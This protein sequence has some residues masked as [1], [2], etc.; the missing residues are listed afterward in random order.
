MRH[1]SFLKGGDIRK[2][3][4]AD[5]CLLSLLTDNRP[6]EKAKSSGPS[7]Q[8][9]QGHLFL[10]P[11]CE[12][13]LLSLKRL[14]SQCEAFWSQKI[15]FYLKKKK[16][17]EW[18]KGKKS[19]KISLLS[20]PLYPLLWTSFPP[21]LIGA[22]SVKPLHNSVSGEILALIRVLWGCKKIFFLLTQ[23][24]GCPKT[25]EKMKSNIFFMFIQTSSFKHHDKE[26]IGFIT[27]QY[28]FV[29]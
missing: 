25:E 2:G 8:I 18:K 22:R 11:W 4:W 24:M 23:N 5:S 1:F 29:F 28:T 9:F 17:E 20:T 15:T 10:T 26:V 19:L 27:R 14:F 21:E 16:K 6:G 7:W 3:H 13:F 12:M